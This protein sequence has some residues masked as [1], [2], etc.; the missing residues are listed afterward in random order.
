MLS[1]RVPAVTFIAAVALLG[2]GCTRP[3]NG[4][5][6]AAGIP[7]ATS[8]ATVTMPAGASTSP[9]APAPAPLGTTKRYRDAGVDVRV[10]VAHSRRPVPTHLRGDLVRFDVT[11]EVTAGT[12]TFSPDLVKHSWDDGPPESGDVEAGPTG[13]V[14]IRAGG[15]QTWTLRFGS[16]AMPPRAVV[17]VYAKPGTVL[18]Y[19]GR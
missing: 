18:G 16:P 11:V 2:A 8:T 17:I 13:S 6:S 1:L 19:W 10:T 7:T 4:P 12:F 15:H 9:T 3:A 14:P 5:E